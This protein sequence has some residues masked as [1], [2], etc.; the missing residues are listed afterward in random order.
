[1]TRVLNQ[2]MSGAVGLDECILFYYLSLLAQSAPECS[3]LIGPGPP[4]TLLSLVEPY[5][6]GAKVY[7]ITTHLKH[8]FLCVVMAR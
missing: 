8:A 7:V 5:Y 2:F 1:M 3:T 4:D 6:D